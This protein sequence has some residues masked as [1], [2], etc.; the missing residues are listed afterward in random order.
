MTEYDSDESDGNKT[1]CD[2]CSMRR[3]SIWVTRHKELKSKG[4]LWKISKTQWIGYA[5]QKSKRERCLST[6]PLRKVKIF[7]FRLYVAILLLQTFVVCLLFCFKK[8]YTCAFVLCQHENMFLILLSCKREFKKRK[9]HMR[10]GYFIFNQTGSSEGKANVFFV[11]KYFW[12]CIHI[13]LHL[14][15]CEW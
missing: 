10:A 5:R 8:H 12:Y 13:W 1:T 14:L 7:T 9:T 15:N 3:P 4:L 2:E 6:F 11:K